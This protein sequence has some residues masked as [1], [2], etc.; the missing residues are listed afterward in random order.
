MSTA[1]QR[2]RRPRRR[3]SEQL[4]LMRRLDDEP[5]GDRVSVGDDVLL[6]RVQIGQRVRPCHLTSGVTNSGANSGL[7]SL[8]T[9]RR[10]ITNEFYV[11]SDSFPSRHVLR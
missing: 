2:T 6:L 10:V 8:N 11:R 1:S 7:C 3:N 4:A 9:R 5:D